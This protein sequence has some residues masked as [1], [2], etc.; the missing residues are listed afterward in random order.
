MWLKE[1]Y[2]DLNAPLPG[3]L[4]GTQKLQTE[5]QGKKTEGLQSLLKQNERTSAS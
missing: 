2:S 3:V 1:Q 4:T 5:L